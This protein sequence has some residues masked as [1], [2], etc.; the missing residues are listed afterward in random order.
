MGEVA[1]V[2][3]PTFNRGQAVVGLEREVYQHGSIGDFITSTIEG[4]P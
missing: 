3:G 2:G 4:E 1:Q